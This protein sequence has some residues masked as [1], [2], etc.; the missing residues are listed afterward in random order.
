MEIKEFVLIGSKTGEIEIEQHGAEYWATIK[1]DGW[2]I[3][4]STQR[5]EIRK[6]KRLDVLRKHLMQ[7][8]FTGTLTV[9]CEAQI[10]LV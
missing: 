2:N 9:S 1:K 5:A 6:W 4:C 7:A 8:G 3:I 10:Q